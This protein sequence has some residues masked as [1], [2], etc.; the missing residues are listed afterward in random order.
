MK[1]IF[2][3]HIKGT[4]HYLMNGFHQ[5]LAKSQKRRVPTPEEDCE[6]ALYRN[7]NREIY[8]PSIQVWASMRNASK[9]FK[10]RGRQTFWQVLN[11]SVFV[12]PEEIIISPQTFSQFLTGVV[13]NRS[14]V[15][16]A[17][18]RFENWSLEFR[19]VN[20]EESLT[21]ET[22]K[23]I[24]QEAGLRHG[25][26]DWRPRF[27]TYEVTEWKKFDRETPTPQ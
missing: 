8:V 19:I 24:L 9:A 16:K 1:E 20:T 18:P 5:D 14:R 15:M 3:V 12:E 4:K 27:G 10:F 13:I 7:A 23:A 26:G 21:E 25:I 6:N 2:S 22:L 11:S 17:R